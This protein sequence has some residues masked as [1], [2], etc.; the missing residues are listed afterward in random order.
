MIPV[1]C[2]REEPLVGDHAFPDAWREHA[3]QGSGLY[4]PP[5]ERVEHGSTAIALIERLVEE[6]EDPVVLAT[7]PLTNLADALA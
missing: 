7:G 5:T 3:D 1:A 6:H 4:L 2:G